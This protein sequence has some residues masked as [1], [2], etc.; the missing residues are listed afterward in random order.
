MD[1]ATVKIASYISI[2]MIDEL[3]VTLPI[4]A[5]VVKSIANKNIGRISG[6]SKIGNNPLL[7]DE[8]DTNA[9][10]IVPATAM[11][12]MPK[13]IVIIKCNGSAISQSNKITNV[14]TKNII[15]INI[16]SSA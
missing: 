10:I 8:T 2:A 5:L 15:S 6:N 7:K 14:G 1:A 16:D 4:N 11:P 12:H 13:I 9:E 3:A